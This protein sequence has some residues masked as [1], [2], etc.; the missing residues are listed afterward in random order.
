MPLP[1]ARRTPNQHTACQEACVWTSVSIKN[2][3]HSYNPI[4]VVFLPWLVFLVLS[5]PRRGPGELPQLLARAVLSL[6]GGEER[7]LTVTVACLTLGRAP[8]NERGLTDPTG[9]N[10]NPR[11][12]RGDGDTVVISGPRLC[13]PLTLT[14]DPFKLKPEALSLLQGRGLPAT[15]VRSTSGSATSNHGGWPG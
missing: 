11:I 2:D 12:E 6:P 14:P 8:T 1:N 5:G 7:K 10:C 3:K 13:F 4:N 15:R 9:S